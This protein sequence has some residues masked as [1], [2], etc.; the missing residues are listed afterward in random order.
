MVYVLLYEPARNVRDA[1][2]LMEQNSYRS[3]TQAAPQRSARRLR[4]E[5]REHALRLPTVVDL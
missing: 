4:P 3:S 1:C 5:Q 2:T